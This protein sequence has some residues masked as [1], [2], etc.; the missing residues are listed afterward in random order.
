LVEP[1]AEQMLAHCQHLFGEWL[2]GCHD[3]KVEL[4]WTD[5]RD[6]KLSHAAIF[7]TDQLDELVTQALERNRIEGCNVYIGQAL[8]KPDI[9]P[10]GRCKD[11]DFFALTACYVDLDD[12]VRD[13][14]RETY[15]RAGCPPTAVVVTGRHPHTRC[16]LLWR[17]ETPERDPDL[18]R[19][20]NLA[21]ARA[22]AGDPTVVNP[23]RVLRLG[24]SIAWP[25][26]PGRIIER[27]EFCLLNGDGR[28]RVYLDGQL[29]K[30]FPP[31]QAK[32]E[33]ASAKP[34][35]DDEF[36][37]VSVESC[38]AAIRAGNHWHDHLV[39]LNRSLG[40]SRLE[41][42]GDPARLREPDASRLD[43]RANGPR[44]RD[45]GR[46]RA[47]KMEYPES[48]ACGRGPAGCVAARPAGP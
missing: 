26:K 36:G 9:P 12:D 7:G 33:G 18:C 32:D 10:F 1:D 2:D 38:L 11:E 48:R 19:A 34:N 24:G 4:A 39:R 42:R 27:T 15:R 3:G 25:V 40:F 16:Q 37:G 14:A 43:P 13:A 23:G 28:P 41:R 6:G 31:V 45:D 35:F 5:P 21:L 47:Q 17:L 22:L 20:Q 44:G 29:A 8:R 30:A 46:G